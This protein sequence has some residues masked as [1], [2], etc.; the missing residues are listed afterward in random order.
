MDEV[1]IKWNSENSVT[2]CGHPKLPSKPGTP[3]LSIV[4]EPE[5]CK[6]VYQEDSTVC[7]ICGS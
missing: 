7:T 4:I 6:H 2:V 3:V 5:P 1:N